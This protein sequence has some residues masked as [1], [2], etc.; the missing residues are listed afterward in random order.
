MLLKLYR[1]LVCSQLDCGVF[2]YKSA[3]KSYLKKLYPIHYEGLKL[4]LGAFRTSPVVCLYTQAHETPLQLRCEKLALQYYT[5][6]KSC[7]SNPAYNCI[8]NC[9]YKQQCEQKE[10]KNIK[11]FGLRVE[12]ILQ[13]SEISVTFVHKSILPQIPL[14][15]IKNPQVI[16]QLNKL[17]KTKTHRSTFTISHYPLTPSWLSIYIYGWLQG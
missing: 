6:L 7:P 17:P 3:K 9:K 13:E 12:P 11:P 8:Y 14:W 4:V 1:A 5:K 15:I 10:K 16:L 2:I